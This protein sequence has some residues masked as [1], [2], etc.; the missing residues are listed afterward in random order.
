MKTIGEL[1]SMLE[2]FENQDAIVYFDFCRCFPTIVDSWRGVYAEA[3][4]GW[5]AEG[6]LN[7]TPKK[8]KELVDNL[9]M[10]ASKKITFFG[11][12]GGEYVY[13]MDTEIHIDNYGS[14]T[15]TEI[16][17]IIAVF[18]DMLIITTYNSDV[19]GTW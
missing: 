17:D 1:I 9:R 4:L 8:A 3:A 2:A 16:K 11:Y 13:D 15:H 19:D 18:D 5:E 7:A 14:C 6:E 12:K 10:A